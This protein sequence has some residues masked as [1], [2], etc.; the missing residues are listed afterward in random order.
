M[1]SEQALSEE[2]SDSI[3]GERENAV[4]VS[5]RKVFDF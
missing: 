3:L 5:G 2:V 1:S 4:E